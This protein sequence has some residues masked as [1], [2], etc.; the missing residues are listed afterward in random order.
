MFNQVNLNM[1]DDYT[2]IKQSKSFI[3]LKTVHRYQAG[4][5]A[6]F[7]NHKIASYRIVLINPYFPIDEIEKLIKPDHVRKTNFTAWKFY[8][9]E[10][11]EK[12]WIMLQLKYE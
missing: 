6:R 11:A 3:F 8:N 10:R 7:Q 4:K 9:Y 1:E 5:G 12:A 2:V